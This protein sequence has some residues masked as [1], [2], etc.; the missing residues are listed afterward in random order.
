[1]PKLVEVASKYLYVREN[2]PGS[3]RSPEIDRWLKAVGSPLGSAWCAA[4]V[5]GCLDEAGEAPKLARSGRVQ[6]IVDSGVLLPASKAV[7]GNLVV[8][9]F[10]NLGR[11]AH[12]GIVVTKTSKR[13]D[14][15]EG[16]T[17]ADGAVGDQREG[18]G[19]FQKSRPITARIKVLRPKTSPA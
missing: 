17:V 8:F 18:W 9:W 12:I 14:V 4:F 11:Y 6:T 3:N 7:P 5:W 15:I 2:P 1:M 13:L 16:N 19:V 10:K